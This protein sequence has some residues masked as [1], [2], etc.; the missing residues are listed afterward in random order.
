MQTES[1]GIK[2]ALQ[3]LVHYTYISFSS[4]PSNLAKRPRKD[5]QLQATCAHASSSQGS[6][7]S[8]GESE[9][10][11]ASSQNPVTLLSLRFSKKKNK[12]KTKVYY[13]SI[14]ELNLQGVKDV[15]TAKQRFCQKVD[16]TLEH[17]EHIK[18]R[19][20]E[21]FYIG[22]TYIPKRKD[23]EFNPADPMTWRVIGVSD[24]YSQH[25]QCDYGR[26]GMI[27][28][29]VITK[30]NLPKNCQVNHEKLALAYEQMLL[31]HYMLYNC[32]KRVANITFD[33]G[34]TTEYDIKR[35]SRDTS[36][37]EAGNTV[38]TQDKEAETAAAAEAGK[39]L[40]EG[41]V[42]TE[43]YPGYAIY[44]AYGLKLNSEH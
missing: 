26:S 37:E 32:D 2:L 13:S 34:R 19:K 23:R 16:S 31:H 38:M 30:D 39:K 6:S 29:G 10:M 17:V 20:I 41:K 22:K 5:S 28:L 36:E 4:S 27:V 25:K 3:G 43:K 7:N 40:T 35:E 21:K 1:R 42:E 24:R 9:T 18:K 44:V 33:T 12:Q 15:E 14:K 11:L 8:S